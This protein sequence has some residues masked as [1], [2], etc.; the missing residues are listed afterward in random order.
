MDNKL[1]K[2]DSLGR[3]REWSIAIGKD[4][5]GHY[6]E[7]THGQ[8]DGKMQVA[9]TY[10]EAGKNIGRSNET[11]P[12]E[13]A[14]FEAQAEY[15]KQ[16]DRE[17]YSENIPENKPLKPM[18]AKKYHDEKGKIVYPCVVQPK[19]DGSRTFAHVTKDGCKLISRQLKEYTGLDHITN[20]L[21]PLHKKYGDFIL[22]GELFNPDLDFQTIMSLVR[23]TKNYT[24]ESTQIQLWVYDMVSEDTFHQRFINWSYITLN[25]TNVRQV[26]TH[27][28]KS[29][30]EIFRFHKKFVHEGYEGTMIRNL[31]SEYKINGRSSDLLK[32]KDFLDEEFKIVGFK[33]GKGKFENIPT[34]EL[35]T[36]TGAT[37]E[38]VPKGTE[39]QRASYLVN[40]E[41]YIGKLATV[42]FFEY[43]TSDPPVPRFPVIVDLDRQDVT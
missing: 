12:V 6:Y 9:R 2:K 39:E 17:G 24:K 7:I 37:F 20:E 21:A 14:K 5:R 36:S 16:K 41:S 13:Q 38:A 42:R 22:D 32:L 8:K 34:F 15:T 25:L 18:L 11:S 40:A 26:A 4:I 3:I 19:L 35:I 23:K 10:V 30:D 28:V 31:G 43:T 33:S 1:Y 29:E 27:I